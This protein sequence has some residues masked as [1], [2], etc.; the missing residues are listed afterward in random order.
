MAATCVARVL[1]RF[2]TGRTAAASYGIGVETDGGIVLSCFAAVRVP[3]SGISVASVGGVI[4]APHCVQN[5]S[6][7]S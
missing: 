4:G 7:L 2:A 6:S 3:D 1:R 5:W